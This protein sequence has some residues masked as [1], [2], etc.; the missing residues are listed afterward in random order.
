M[1]KDREYFIFI[2][3]VISVLVGGLVAAACGINL[4]LGIGAGVLLTI[5]ISLLLFLC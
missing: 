1:W 4:W 2:L 3:G 5:V